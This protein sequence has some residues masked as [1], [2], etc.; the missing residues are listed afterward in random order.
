VRRVCEMPAASRH[1][2]ETSE[3]PSRD[4]KVRKPR[5]IFSC[6]QLDQLSA[7]FQRTQYLPLP[8]RAE[9]ASRLGLTQ[10]QVPI[11]CMLCSQLRTTDSQF[12]TAGHHWSAGLSSRCRFPTRN[13]T[14]RYASAVRARPVGRGVRWVRTQPPPPNK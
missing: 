1:D 13:G 11:L 10:T 3:S 7:G 12:H 2:A 8:E 9:L 4:S 5:T 6:Y 14:R